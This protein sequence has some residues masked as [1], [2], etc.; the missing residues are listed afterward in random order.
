VWV[1]RVRVPRMT[2]G[3]LK[4]VMMRWWVEWWGGGEGGVDRKGREAE[5]VR[6]R[7]KWRRSDSVIVCECSIGLGKVMELL[8][9]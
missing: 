6:G 3:R 7:G 8:P 1:G 2:V 4:V 5:A 9:R